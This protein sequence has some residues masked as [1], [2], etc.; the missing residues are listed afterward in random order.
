MNFEENRVKKILQFLTR[1]SV[2][3]KY[4]N[5]LFTQPNFFFLFLSN[6]SPSSFYINM[7]IEAA[8]EKIQA[9]SLD[10][11]TERHP[12]DQQEE[13]LRENT[14]RFCLFPIKYHEV[15]HPKIYI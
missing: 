12:D 10:K 8:T 5:A 2:T 3:K 11:K 7:S 13:I 1:S 4:L 9:L 14:R 6:I 15:K